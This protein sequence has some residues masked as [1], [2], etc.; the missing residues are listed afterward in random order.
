M[1][2]RRRTDNVSHVDR[3][4]RTKRYVHRDCVTRMTMT[5]SLVDVRR[6]DFDFDT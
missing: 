3:V 1:F 2:A 5:N 4:Q 6:T